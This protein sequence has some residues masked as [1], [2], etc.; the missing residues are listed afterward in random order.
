M[1]WIKK[2]IKWLAWGM[3]LLLLFISLANILV[4]ASSKKEVKD[5]IGQL[6]DS[7][8]GLVLG[9][10]K[11]TRI[12]TDNLFF[13]DRMEAA[14]ELYLSG[15]VKHLIV[16]GDNR[17]IYYNEPQDMLEALEE[18]GVPSNAITLDHGG[19]RTLDSVVRCR[20]I[21]GQEDIII[22]TQKFHA[23]RAVFI[24]NKYDI[25]AQ[26][27]AANFESKTVIK[28]LIRE[29]VARPLAI[30]DIYVLNRSP[31]YLGDKEILEIAE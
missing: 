5:E 24:A 23:Y 27:Y 15:K 22:V 17:T 1:T 18:L 25:A 12:G 2:V 3:T 30:L 13:T 21:F 11:S 10:S 14:A 8:I 29:M 4:V 19:L 28:L 31:K 20:E 26:A 16:S 6:K 9:T 7:K